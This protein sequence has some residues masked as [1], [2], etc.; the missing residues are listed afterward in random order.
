[1]HA[2]DPEA[3][4]LGMWL[5]LLTEIL[6]FGGLFL[7][8]AS[9]LYRFPD[10]FHAGGK[11][12]SL[13]FGTVNTAILLISSWAVAMSISALHRDRDSLSRKM[14]L[15]T[16]GLGLVFLVNKAFEWHGKIAAG[17]YPDSP[18]LNAKPDGEVLFFGLYYLMT[19]LHGI[20]VLIGCCLLLFAYWWLR[21]G[22]IH[23]TDYAL[24]E[25]VGL[26]WHLVDLIWVFLFPLFYLIA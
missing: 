20:H 21:I 26:Y 2:K 25:N 10:E 7:L 16:I 14:L 6:L 23:R 1:M 9:Y 8:Y 15:L 17:I 19:G 5:F 3:A 12:L 4:K 13:F 18:V 24:L 22:K 11:Q